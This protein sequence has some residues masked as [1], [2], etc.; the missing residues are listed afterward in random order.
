MDSI[1]T[2][3]LVIGG[4][5][6]G[7]AIAREVAKDSIDTI[8]VEMNDS[9]GAEVSSRNSGVIHA[10]FYYPQDSLKA[11]FCNNGNKLLY[12]FC[13][14]NNVFTKKTG[15]ILVSSNSDALPVFR[16]YQERAIAA[17]GESLS[18]LHRDELLSLEPELSSSYGL[19]SPETGII[20]VHGLISALEQDFLNSDHGLVSLHTRLLS[21]RLINNGF[22][23]ILRSGSE[24]FEVKSKKVIFAAGLD[25]FTLSKFT[26][27]NNHSLVEPVNYSKG[28]YFKLS[29]KSPF[30]HLIYPMPT[31]FGLGI[32]SSP[33]IDG[34]IRFGPDASWVDEINYKFSPGI[35]SSFVSSILEYWPAL[36]EQKL[37]EDYVGIRPKIQKPDEPFK[38]FSILTKVDHEI[39]NLV[40]LQ[41]IESPGITCSIPIAQY[42]A[43][44]IKI[45]S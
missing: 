42:V 16:S 45:N 35:K 14:A 9:L 39:D 36:D 13:S 20:D 2:E 41:G 11:K 21:C 10:G 28:H 15:K 1:S 5:V 17:G 37:H 30:Q 31:Q 3:C 26:P 43:N 34:S 25:S 29:G 23:S 19:Y 8:L 44:A 22:I 18:I 32:H 12:D 40:F 27:L 4:G 7:V 6:I 24:E 33:D 38:D